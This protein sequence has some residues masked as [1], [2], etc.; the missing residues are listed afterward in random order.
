MI[1][2]TVPANED[3]FC[4]LLTALLREKMTRES[5][6]MVQ[7]DSHPKQHG[8]VKA[9]FTV[10]DDLASEF[11]WGVL[12]PAA[13][14]Q[15]WVRFSNQHAP[16]QS[17]RKKD[18]RGAAIKLINIKG[19]KLNTPDGNRSS[20]DFVVISTPVFVTRDVRE[21]YHL[22]EALVA[23]K[24]ALL[25]HFLRHP[26]SLW[27]FL[28]S[29][30]THYSPLNIRYWSTTPYLL[31]ADKVVKYSLIPQTKSPAKREPSAGDDFLRRNMVDQLSQ[32]DYLFDFCIQEQKNPRSM[33]IEDP[34]KRWSER[35]SPFIKVATLTIAQQHFDSP[36]Q[37]A[38]GRDLSFN[39]WHGLSA[40]KPLGGINRARRKVYDQLSD[41]RHQANQA[42]RQEPTNMNVPTSN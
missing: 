21:F 23:G 9:H 22:I 6:T 2:E 4:Q 8:L 29:N 33:P 24:P 1:Q 15:A 38:Y 10:V 31:G 18:I 28:C 36:S 13:Q 30:K 12:Q 41:F 39:P 14:Y 42:P 7:R 5:T 20:Q 25:W 11:R 26:R 32:R 37:H 27:N 19:N 16:P 35:R 34:G 3:H 40:H 17:D